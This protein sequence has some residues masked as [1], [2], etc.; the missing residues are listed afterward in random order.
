MRLRSFRDSRLGKSSRA[1]FFFI[2]WQVH[3][4]EGFLHPEHMP[5]LISRPH[6]LHGLQPHDWHMMFPLSISLLGNR[7]VLGTVS[8][9]TIG[10]GEN[11]EIY[12]LQPPGWG[13]RFFRSGSGDT[14]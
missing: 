2:G 4:A 13:F 12:S 10:M 5:S 6:F 7:S 11:K 9:Y 1:Y 8:H 14:R 3:W